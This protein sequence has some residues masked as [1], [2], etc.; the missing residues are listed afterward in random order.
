MAH[1]RKFMKELEESSVRVQGSRFGIKDTVP[2]LKRT[3]T[4][5][6]HNILRFF[7]KVHS[8]AA[9]D[10]DRLNL[11]VC[12]AKDTTLAQAASEK[13]KL[14]KDAGE[15]EAD[16]WTTF[17]E[18]SLSS[19][20]ASYRTSIRSK[21]LLPPLFSRSES[22]ADLR[23]RLTDDFNSYDLLAELTGTA[24]IPIDDVE[25]VEALKQAVPMEWQ[26]QI[27]I[28]AASTPAFTLDQAFKVLK[29]IDSSSG[30]QQAA[31]YGT[32]I[33]NLPKRKSKAHNKYRYETSS[34]D[35]S[36]SDDAPLQ[37]RP[38]TKKTT[39]SKVAAAFQLSLDTA[40]GRI[41]AISKKV[42]TSMDSANA[43]LDSN[44][45]QM[46]TKLAAAFLQQKHQTSFASPPAT[47][48]PNSHCM[49][50]GQEGH[51]M[52]N[53]P[54]IHK[55]LQPPLQSRMPPR[56]TRKMVCYSCH[57]EGHMSNTCPSRVC[58]ICN[59]P[60]HIASA[61]PSKPN[62]SKPAASFPNSLGR[63]PLPAGQ[64]PTTYPRTA[65]GLAG[66]TGVRIG[67][68]CPRCPGQTHRLA[69]CPLYPGCGK[70]GSKDHMQYRC[71]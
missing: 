18:G 15:F 14:A 24:G 62:F 58:F 9:T 46:N 25:K 30:S 51:W 23:I 47:S 5:N 66:G 55:P 52:H 38:E 11:V 45:Q 41:G 26:K 57:Q 67:M 35:G 1:S 17:C 6:E 32:R 7:V 12:K 13:L 34:S 59:A 53:C 28:T 64:P 56:A 69:S 2:T 33:N 31:T 10:A 60:G 36:D 21:V 65:H 48:I 50:C 49:S 71:K 20:N 3:E 27:N 70:C 16:A 29:A 61:C 22:L 4:D 68:P 40:L 63:P 37:A 42:D 19:N 43:T 8:T 44:L 39:K 54:K